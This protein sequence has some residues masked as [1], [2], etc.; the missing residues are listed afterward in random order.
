MRKKYRASDEKIS[1]SSLIA[2]LATM[3]FTF[4][5]GIDFGEI[6]VIIDIQFQFPKRVN[7]MIPRCKISSDKQ[8]LRSKPSISESQMMIQP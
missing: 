3:N 7:C 4:L 2:V 8:R 1:F 6:E 5:K